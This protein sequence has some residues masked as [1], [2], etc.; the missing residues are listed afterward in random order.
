MMKGNKKRV[1]KRL[2]L[3]LAMAVALGT[4]AS[5][6]LM[7]AA[8]TVQAGSV[9]AF[10]AS[11]VYLG[12]DLVEYQGQT[13]KALWWT[14]GTV[15]GSA[16]SAWE[17]QAEQ[18]ADGTES[19]YEGR[20]FTGGQTVTYNGSV[21]RA[22]WWTNSVPGSDSSWSYVGPA[23]DGDGGNVED[24]GNTEDGGNV[25]EGGNT[26][27]G[28]N[29]EDGGNTEDDG[30]VE[31]GGN[32][33]DDGNTGE[34]PSDIPAYVSGSVYWKGDKVFYNGNVYEAQWWTM[35][36]PGSDSS[37]KQITVLPSNPGTNPGGTVIPSEGTKDFKIVGYYPAWKP[38]KLDTI[39]YDNLTN[40]I[41][42]F[43]IP[44]GNGGL[45]P[46]DNPDLAKTIIE[47]A[48]ANG[49]KVSI[50]VGGW[51]YNGT[52]LETAFI[53]S[54]NTDAKVESFAQA[55]VN[56]MNQYGFDGIDMDWEH[57]RTDGDS[58]KQ[59]DKLMLRLREKMGYDKILTSA[60]LGGVTA[61]GIKLYDAAAHTDA[62]ISVVDWFN[63]MAY[64]GGDGDRHSGYEFAVNCALYWRDTRNMPA[65]KVVLGVPF[66][67]RPSWATYEEILANDPSAY[68][69]DVSDYYGKQAYYNGIPTIQ[70]KTQ[71]ACD[72]VGGIMIWEIAQD[73]SNPSTSLLTAIANKAR[74]NNKFE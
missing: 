5:P 40:I 7:P 67:G 24:G 47:R 3:A 50:A 2:A 73:S 30:N 13:Y 52:P 21:Y 38:E 45:L 74:E 58:S 57:P 19:Y 35:T 20:V 66:Y 36:I 26:E 22:N 62:V 43:A 54:T 48:H 68:S 32:T 53:S 59:Y 70:K 8:S 11:K 71:W 37:W 4:V 28:G 69:K 25:E 63:V 49:V 55:I 44:D 41:Y 29:I 56:M 9:A 42:A 33:E 46:L 17:L 23:S 72:N 39:Q 31:D 61:D 1:A 6:A 14:Q 60:V 34:T 10:D 27:D 12:G 51:E 18:N 65:N 16:G 64:D 15:P